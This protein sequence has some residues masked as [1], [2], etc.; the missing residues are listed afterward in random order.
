[1]ELELGKRMFISS[2]KYL[3]LTNKLVSNKMARC[4]YV[5]TRDECGITFK[6]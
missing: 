5:I 1:M 6:N 2:L 3:P 4:G